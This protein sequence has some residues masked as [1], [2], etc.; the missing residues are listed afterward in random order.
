M[1]RLEKIWIKNLKNFINLKDHQK[2]M[3]LELSLKYKYLSKWVKKLI[4]ILNE[5]LKQPL[6]NIW[7]NIYLNYKK[8]NQE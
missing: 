8:I 3:R 7:K 1:I 2:K 4:N 5:E 6:S